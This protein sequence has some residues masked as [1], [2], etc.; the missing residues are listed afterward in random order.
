MINLNHAVQFQHNLWQDAMA[1]AHCIVDATVGNGHDFLYL[2]NHCA[3]HAALFGFDIQLAAIKATQE[4]M[5]ECS[6]RDISWQLSLGDHADFLGQDTPLDY[7]IDLAVFNL[8]Y[9]PSGDHSLMTKADTTIRALQGAISH[10]APQGMITVVA[11]PGTPEGAT[12]EAAVLEYITGLPQRNYDVS[13]WRPLNQRN[14][15]PTLY[16]LRGR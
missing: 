15:P 8:G 4:R 12:E 9:L 14:Q 16:I 2:A 6:R 10:L 3:P 11:Y 1:K 13:T 5:K 7:P